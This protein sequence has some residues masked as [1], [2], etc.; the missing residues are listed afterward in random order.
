[1][2]SVGRVA[3]ARPASRGDSGLRALPARGVEHGAT[4][5]MDLSGQ[6]GRQPRLADADRRH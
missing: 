1:M 6:L 3:S 5:A 4:G 2:S